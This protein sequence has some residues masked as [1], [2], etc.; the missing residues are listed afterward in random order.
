MGIN[1]RLLRR[2]QK[3]ILAEPRRLVMSHW[4]QTRLHECRV[5]DLDSDHCH[6]YPFAK[7]GTA[8]CIGGWGVILSD[9]DI[10]PYRQRDELAQLFGINTNQ[11]NLLFSV[12]SWP[13]KLAHAYRK[14]RT[15][16]GKARV[17]S[18]RIDLFIKTRGA[19]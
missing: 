11:L 6:D 15:P 14:A 5:E 16:A 4:R 12:S 18:R 13:V 2:V 7:C 19:E 1:V 3:H 9:S 17:A 8:A 10:A